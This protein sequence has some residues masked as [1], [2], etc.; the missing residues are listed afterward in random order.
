MVG[1][2]EQL[3]TIGELAVEAGVTVR[4][5]RHYDNLDLLAPEERSGG[6][7][8]RYSRGDVERLYRILALRGLGFGL[9]EIASLIDGDE[10]SLPAATRGQ[11]ARIDEQI[12]AAEQLRQRLRGVLQALDDTEEPSTEQLIDTMEAMSM[13][14][15][16][17]RIYTRAGD[18]GQTR[19]GDRSP[20]AK[21]APVIAAGG[22]VDELNAQIGQALTIA[23]MPDRPRRWL[24]RIQNDLFDLGGDLSVPWS[25][26]GDRR[27]GRIDAGYV[28]WLEEVCDEVNAGL[29][30]LGSF[31]IPGGSAASAQLHVCRTVCRRAERAVLG[32]EEVNPEIV[33]YLNRLSDLLFILAR[34]V[35][36]EPETLWEPGG[37][38]E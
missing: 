33:R 35:N 7:H 5:L 36:A 9:R 17:T 26:E 38:A 10:G 2:D 19:R 3:W 25:P 30:P 37:H 27:E 4:T 32:A 20:V 21:T 28:D 22:D 14:V 11:L 34:S 29:E 1:E 6:G 24:A 31:A 18:A 23:A 8:R 16:L 12:E 13:A 15:K